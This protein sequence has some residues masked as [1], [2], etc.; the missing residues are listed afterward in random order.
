[1]VRMFIRHPVSDYA[2]W[3]AAYDAFD[4]ERAGIGV[5]AHAVYSEASDPNDVMVTHD[6]DDLSTAQSFAD[7]SRLREV[8]AD[9]GVAGAPTIWFANQA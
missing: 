9:A 6:F 2:K 1:M 8:M 5:T 7:S 4:E 3:R